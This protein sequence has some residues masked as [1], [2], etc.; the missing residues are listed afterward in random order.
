M[1]TSRRLGKVASDLVLV[2]WL[3]S[4]QPT[5]AWARV[6]DLQRECCRCYSVGFVVHLD[7]RVI[8]LAPNMADVDE[9]A[10]ASG[11]MVIP[12]IAVL[13]VTSLTSTSRYAHAVSKRRQQRISRT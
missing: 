1:D 8:V 3:D 4:R 9:E 2:E 7:A 10:Q 13:G 6:E 5:T 11:V 12:R